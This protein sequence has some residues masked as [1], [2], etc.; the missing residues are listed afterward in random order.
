MKKY[1]Y[2][3][4]SNPFI[5]FFLLIVL[6]FFSKY[7]LFSKLQMKDL[8]F[9]VFLLTIFLIVFVFI[10]SWLFSYIKKRKYLNSNLYTIDKMN[11]IEFENYLK[12][13]FQKL[14][15]NVKKTTTTNDYG[16]DL[17]CFKNGEKIVIQAKRYSGKVGIKAVQ[18]IVSAKGFYGACKAIVVTNSYYTKNAITLA[19][20]NQVELWDRTNITTHF[21]IKN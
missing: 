19:S 9:Y 11:G 6:F 12:S 18:E 20:A 3:K 13:H 2:K 1:Y 7:K 5:F 4:N 10:L 14:G 8:I 21:S 17:V 16:A 15:Y